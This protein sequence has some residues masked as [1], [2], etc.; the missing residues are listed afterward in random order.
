MCYGHALRDSSHATWRPA[1]TQDCHWPNT[2][3]VEL[4]LLCTCAVALPAEV[5]AFGRGLSVLR[6]VCARRSS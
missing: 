5:G 4:P 6:V 1:D 2:T 3:A